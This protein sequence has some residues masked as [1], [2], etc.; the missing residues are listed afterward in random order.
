LSGTP[1]GRID[2]RF[3]RGREIDLR[4]LRG[5]AAISIVVLFGRMRR[6]ERWERGVERVAESRA[7]VISRSLSASFEF[8]EM[9]LPVEPC[10][11]QW[12]IAL[13]GEGDLVRVVRAAETHATAVQRLEPS[14]VGVGPEIDLKR[15]SRLRPVAAVG[16]MV[17]QLPIDPIRVRFRLDSDDLDDLEVI[18]CAKI[19]NQFVH[20]ECD[21]FKQLV[22]QGISVTRLILLP[23]LRWAVA[24]VGFA[25]ES[26]R[27][28]SA[29]IT[30][31]EE[32]V[33]RSTNVER[34]TIQVLDRGGGSSG[35]S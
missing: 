29:A 23:R 26:L 21:E 9:A 1:I 2:F 10:V 7:G 27:E 17:H 13:E 15:E 11:R 32:H 4:V 30:V 16:T 3:D 14:G 31:S 34:G 35:A 18:S 25:V 22:E 19:A 5:S 33:L 28:P 12:G 20:I 24:P 8:R 6:R